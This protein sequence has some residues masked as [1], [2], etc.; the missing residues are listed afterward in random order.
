MGKSTVV[1]ER[2]SNCNSIDK[3]L[4]MARKEIDAIQNISE[5]NFFNFMKSRV[6]RTDAISITRYI[7]KVS[8]KILAT[9]LYWIAFKAYQIGDRIPDEPY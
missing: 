9:P 7:T 3:V 8:A 5:E 6:M 4:E 2:D 1:N